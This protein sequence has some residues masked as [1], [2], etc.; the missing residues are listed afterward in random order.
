MHIIRVSH[1][2]SPHKIIAL[3][4]ATGIIVGRATIMSASEYVGPMLALSIETKARFVWYVTHFGSPW[5][6]IP[7]W[8]LAN[9][10]NFL[11]NLI[12]FDRI[13]VQLR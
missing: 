12:E 8:L 6:Q 1:G 13:P 10:T 3:G 2:T 9:S 4:V 7:D 5:W 11:S